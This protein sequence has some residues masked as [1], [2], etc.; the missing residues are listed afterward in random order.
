MATV[1]QPVTRSE[2]R[3]ELE[4]YATKADLAQLETRLT[5]KLSGVLVT[6]M[7]VIT[8]ILRYLA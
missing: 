7:A 8:V 6:G 4:R 2:L 1:A 3:K 5:W